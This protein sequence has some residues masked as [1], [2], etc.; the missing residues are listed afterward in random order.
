MEANVS[1]QEKYRSIE[2][3]FIRQIPTV[4]QFSAIFADIRDAIEAHA[5]L[6][7]IKPDWNVVYATV[8][9]VVQSKLSGPFTDH[10]SQENGQ[11]VVCAFIEPN[12]HGREFAE[13][14]DEY[15]N[16]LFSKFGS[17][18][19]CNRISEDSASLREYRVEYYNIHH[20]AHAFSC[21]S[22]LLLGVSYI[23]SAFT[24]FHADVSSAFVS[25]SPTNQPRFEHLVLAR[26]PAL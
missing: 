7:N 25:M 13:L 10:L 22:G 26:L 11:L 2:G 17:V 12:Q 20:A 16:Q 8:H 3:V 4:G 23:S 14:T 5:Y 6:C 15:V 24:V 19:N 18:R 9:E 21:L 1:Q